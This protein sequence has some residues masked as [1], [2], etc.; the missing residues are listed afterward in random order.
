LDGKEELAIYLKEGALTTTK[1]KSE[2]SSA[3][4]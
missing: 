1:K 2:L 4:I 3:L